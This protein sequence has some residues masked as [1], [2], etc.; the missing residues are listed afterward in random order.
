MVYEGG[1]FY[2]TSP[3]LSLM[4]NMCE[5]DQKYNNGSAI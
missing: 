3:N 2:S 5:S 4:N 1:V